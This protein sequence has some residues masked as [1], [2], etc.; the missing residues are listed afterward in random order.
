MNGPEKA[1]GKRQEARNFFP[2]EIESKL[3]NPIGY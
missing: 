1:R 2:G 3:L